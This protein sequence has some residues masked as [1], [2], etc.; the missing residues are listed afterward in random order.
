MPLLDLLRQEYVKGR[1]VDKYGLW[2]EN[3]GLV[4]EDDRARHLL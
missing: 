2:N 3:V 1:V 4:I